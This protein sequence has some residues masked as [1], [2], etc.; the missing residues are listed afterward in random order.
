MKAK[1]YKQKNYYILITLKI[2]NNLFVKNL[3]LFANRIQKL[4]NN[5]NKRHKIK[6]LK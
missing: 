1:L 2:K 3:K 4:F 6:K 5:S